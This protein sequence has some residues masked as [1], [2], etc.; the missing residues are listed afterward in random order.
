MALGEFTKQ[1]AQQAIL[2]ATTKEPAPPAPAVAAPE[3]VTGVFLAQI[4]GMQKALKEDEELVV[5]CGELRV[6]EIFAPS[7]QVV[8]LTGTQGG[9]LTRIVAAVE[10]LQLTCKVAKAQAGAKAARVALITPKQKDS[11]A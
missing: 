3:N 6:M 7:R 4:H 9:A 10:S 5:H 11:N 8:V 2:S 1:I